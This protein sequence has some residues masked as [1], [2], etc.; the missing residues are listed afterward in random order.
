MAR[1]AASLLQA[2]RHPQQPRRVWPI[3]LHGRRVWRVPG[4]GY[5]PEGARKQFR[6][7]FFVLVAGAGPAA[8]WRTNL[9]LR[10]YFW[11]SR[12]PRPHVLC[13]GGPILI[14][15]ISPTSLAPMLTP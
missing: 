6:A 15:L 12:D 3:P 7:P 11:D 10:A 2:E 8:L 1:C 4:G 5:K 9:P 13:P 14:L